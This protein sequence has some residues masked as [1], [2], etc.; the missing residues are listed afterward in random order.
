MALPLASTASG[1]A[2]GANAAADARIAIPARATGNTVAQTI[3]GLSY[4][5]DNLRDPRFFAA[6]NTG[7]VDAFR[8]LNP[9]GVLR[10]G[11]NTSDLAKPAGFDGP[12]P[13]LHPLYRDRERVQPYYDVSLDAIDALAGFLD[14]T[15]WKIGYI[16]GPKALT[17]VAIKAH[18]NLTFTTPPNL[19]RAAAV[20]LGRLAPLHPASEIVPA[21]IAALPGESVP[22]QIILV[23]ALGKTT[24][25]QVLE[26]LKALHRS[27]LKQVRSDSSSELKELLASLGIALDGFDGVHTE[28]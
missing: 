7:L 25:R 24:D 20:G 15:G 9:R 4:E 21:F 6:A 5:T 17:S 8:R 10:L 19:Q 1:A 27:V 11:G 16:S 18:Q 23:R 13:V 28:E 3:V 12:L 14:A 22:N 26:P 2:S